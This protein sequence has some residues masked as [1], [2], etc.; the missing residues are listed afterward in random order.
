VDVVFPENEVPQLL[1]ALKVEDPQRHIRL[2]LEVA[3]DI[4]NNQRT[5]CRKG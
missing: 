4:G 5:D 3:Q 1:N 2:T